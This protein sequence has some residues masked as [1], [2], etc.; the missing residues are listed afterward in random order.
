VIIV[1]A[2]AALRQV[3]SVAYNPHCMAPSIESPS[4]VTGP[5]GTTPARLERALGAIRLGLRVTGALGAAL[6]ILLL[7]HGQAHVVP[8]AGLTVAY[9]I[10]PD[11]VTCGVNLPQKLLSTTLHRQVDLTRIPATEEQQDLREALGD[12]FRRRNPVEVDG[13][14][15]LPVLKNLTLSLCLEEPLTPERIQSESLEAPGIALRPG[16]LP[17]A[18]LMLSYPLK[19]EPLEVRLTWDL[20]EA[21]FEPDPSVPDG[22]AED[23]QLV[24][25]LVDEERRYYVAF[26][27]GDPVY[28]WC[29]VGE[30]GGPVAPVA[31]RAPATLALPPVTLLGLLLVVAG[32]VWRRTTG[33]RQRRSVLLVGLVLILAGAWYRPWRVPHPWPPPPALPEP[34]VALQLF[35]AL[36]SNIYRAFDYMDEEAIYET[37]SQSVDGQLLD[38][39]YREV[40]QSLAL[41]EEG[42]A[43]CHVQRVDV[44]ELHFRPE[45][46]AGPESYQVSCRWGVTGTIAHWGHVHRRLNR[47]EALYTVARR[48]DLW[49]LVACQVLQ[50]GRVVSDTRV[51]GAG[52]GATDL[53]PASGGDGG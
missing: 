46:A 11:Q 28:V 50:H 34:E 5:T 19:S 10:G 17:G 8:M 12:L 21:F 52:S 48:G 7:G 39:V 24:A 51:Q 45:R 32:L 41:Q 16:N 25:M 31:P 1:P 15:V 47:Y 22:E 30:A 20:E 43:I 49:K 4:R 26:T 37:L 27:P 33:S 13:L 42:G 14:R 40:Y 36:H 38:E 44:E 23:Q 2:P 53:L 3:E 35:Q 9:S 6:A 18:W 29:Q